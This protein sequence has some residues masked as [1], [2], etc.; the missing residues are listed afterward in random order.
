[1]IEEFSIRRLV[2]L[3]VAFA[4]VVGC[5]SVVTKDPKNQN[6]ANDHAQANNQFTDAPLSPGGTG[7]VIEDQVDAV[8]EETQSFFTA[9]QIDP[10]SED[11]AGPKF[12]IAEDMNQDGLLDLVTAWNESQ[13][14]QM[15]LQQRDADNNI[16]FKAINLGGTSP[17]AISAGVEVGY[18]NDD[19]WLDIVVLVK[20]TGRV[21]ICPP[22]PEES[23]IGVMDGEI[24]ILF[25]PGNAI[26]MEDGARWDMIEIELFAE[27]PGFEHWTLPGLDEVGF[28][29]AATKPELNGFTALAVGEIDGRQG[30]DIVVSFNSAECESLGLKP[31][32]T[33]VEL[34]A[35][36]GGVL[37]EDPTFWT[38]TRLELDAPPVR[39]LLLLDVEQ[40]GDLDVISCWSEA[41]S[42]NVRWARNPLI[43]HQPGGPGGTTE[44]LGGMST[45]EHR[46]IGQVA[47]G[48]DI[49]S[50]GDIDGDG[51]EDVVV[52]S[53]LGQIVQW[54]RRPDGGQSEPVFPPPDPVPD[55]DPPIFPWQVYTLAVFEKQE[56]EGIAVGDI[57]GDGLNE[58]LI[59]AEGAV[60]WYDGTT[61]DSRF[62][63]WIANTVIR[64]SPPDETDPN[65]ST[66][67]QQQPTQPG[68]AG[69]TEVDTSTHINS[70]LV[71]D[72]DGDGKNDIVGTLDRRTG[73]GLSD[74]RLV[75][76]RNIRTD[77]A[78]E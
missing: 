63:E 73:S 18:I 32:I 8:G 70:L 23:I 28:W 60:F 25:N 2:I 19:E 53:R 35:N 56:P 20:A 45:W 64:D 9:Y 26:A 59:A 30:D 11:T 7:G 34:Y 48:A 55:R 13:P 42:T 43:P 14:I 50:L 71:V 10:V 75:W 44:V 22:P 33:T 77:E 31:P 38:N 1:M 66:S 41:T 65:Q 67:Q 72:L 76:Y 36:P 39:D 61:S 74:D 21:T 58:V 57:T 3:F 47:T 5:T 54:F 62:D 69:V 29:E 17:I 46:P 40:D 16:S 37:S 78:P 12:V 15:H 27:I 49:L 24:V 52:R 51:L 6:P 4:V 68:G